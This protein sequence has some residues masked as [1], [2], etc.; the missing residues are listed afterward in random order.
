VP[1]F[2]VVF[3]HAP[4]IYDFRKTA[5]VYGPIADVIPSTPVF[6]MYPIGFF[7]LSSYLSSRG[8]KIGIVNLAARMLLDKDF[9]VERAIK[10]IEAEIFAIDLH[11]MVHSHGA[12]EVAKLVKK[13]HPNSAVVFGGLSATIYYKEVLSRYRQVDYVV[14]GDT[15]EVPLKMLAEHLLDGGRSLEEIPNLAWRD[16]EA[17][18][19]TGIK[20]VPKSLDEYAV[21]YREVVKIA[22]RGGVLS[23]IPFAGFLKEPI[24]AVLSYKGCVFNCATCGGSFCAYTTYFSR[25]CLGVKKPETLVSEIKSLEQYLRVPIFVVGDLQLLGVKWIEKFVEGLRRERFSSEIFFEFFTPPPL[26]VL[27]LLSR[28]ADSVYLQISPETHDESLRLKFGKPYSNSSLEAFIKRALSLEFARLD[29]YFMVGIPGQT[30][31]S[32]LA[33]PNYVERLYEQLSTPQRHRLDVFV[34]PLAPFIDPG[35]RA[36]ENPGAFGYKLRAR[37]LEEHRRLLESSRDWV[38]MLNYESE[39]IS[40]SEIAYAVYQ[41]AREFVKIKAEN[42][43]ISWDQ[44][45]ETLERVEILS[46]GDLVGSTIDLYPSRKL[47]R[48]IRWN[49]LVNLIGFRGLI[50][51]IRSLTPLI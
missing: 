21:D 2:D 8:Y 12:I 36:F 25:R 42:G 50:S 5:K 11:W 10:G 49:R 44:A 16:R 29:L 9:D 15:T 41:T 1:K 45:K 47:L 19:T 32:A 27:K 17:V 33:M 39:Y 48:S 4:S 13:Y 28:A 46:K 7:S 40:R 18:K 14:L 35:S 51:T 34:A 37:T 24:G 43:V 6:D 38:E 26:D 22:A 30:L 20:F 23:A 31:D 3:L